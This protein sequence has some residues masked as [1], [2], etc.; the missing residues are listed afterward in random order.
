MIS[1]KSRLFAA[2]LKRKDSVSMTKIF[3]RAAAGVMALAMCAGLTGCYSENK[4]W[5]VKSGDSTLPI[6]GYIYYLSSAYSEAAGKVGT[7]SEV[8][9]ADLDGQS[10]TEWVKSKAMD[11]LYSYC[12]VNQKFNELGLA[13]DEEELDSVDYV[14]DS[15]W[16]YYRE[17][18]ENMGIA[19]SSFEEAYSVYNAKLS[20]LLGVMYGKGG[21]MEL[22]EEEMHDYYTE[23]YVYYRYMSVGLTTTDEEG[24]S[25]DMDDD[26]KAGIKEYLEDQ[27]EL[28]NSGRADLDT[29]SGN[30]SALHGTEP[31]LNAPMAY[32][33][34]NLSSVF[35]DALEPLKNGGAAFVETTTR[36][37]IVQRL[38]IEE[39]F[40]ALI[41]DESRVT[42]L[43]TEM[44]AEDFSQYTID[45][46]RTMDVEINQSAIN[47]INPSKVANVMGK[48]GVS[49]AESSESSGGAS[50]QAE[51]SESSESSESAESAESE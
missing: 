43:L 34:D 25:T 33:R 40:K 21:E 11:Y 31:D 28:V 36:Y 13:L 18:F 22:S 50:S 38:D 7:G 45:Q 37:Y 27:A 9:K 48:N 26:E 24:N 17:P 1:G 6:G 16:S 20:K 15:M 44:K 35:A 5:A 41:E 47:G 2:C 10:A 23:E 32:K 3:K 12:Y 14:T 4:T 8:L 19:E 42:G 30:Y 49:S 51:S 39:D 29:V 46:G